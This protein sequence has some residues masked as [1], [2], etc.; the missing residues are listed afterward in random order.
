MRALLLLVAAS[1]LGGAP[2]A[3]ILKVHFKD[4]KAAKK[5]K[6]HTTL[7]DGEEVLLGEPVK[8]GGILLTYT[9]GQLTGVSFK[10]NADN[11]FFVLD[12]T[13]PEA[14]P[15]KVE[16]GAKVVTKKSSVETI[17]GKY[18]ERVE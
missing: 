2:A 12:P 1:V 6:K 17:H 10:I 15:Y 4:E 11:E 18:I 7:I 16:K 3:Q 8:D 14:V 5:F 13:D 9:E